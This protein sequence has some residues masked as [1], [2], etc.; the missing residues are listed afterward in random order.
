MQNN[1]VVDKSMLQ[2]FLGTPKGKGVLETAQSFNGSNSSSSEVY[3]DIFSRAISVF[4]QATTSL[5]RSGFDG[6]MRGLHILTH[7]YLMHQSTGPRVCEPH[8]IPCSRSLL[9]GKYVA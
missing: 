8:M 6:Y 9:H 3:S 7:K 5:H 1:R 4:D 2:P